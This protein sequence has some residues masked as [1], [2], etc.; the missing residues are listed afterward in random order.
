MKTD[1]VALANSI[2][3]RAYIDSL[4]RP[5]QIDRLLEQQ[6]KLFSILALWPASCRPLECL[7]IVACS[8]QEAVEFPDVG[9]PETVVIIEDD[10]QPA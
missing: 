3:L 10:V 1:C 5:C 7:T 6:S 9:A 8:V 4:D 2:D